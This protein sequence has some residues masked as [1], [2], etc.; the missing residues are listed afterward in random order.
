M[1]ADA[2]ILLGF[3]LLAVLLLVGEPERGFSIWV[4]LY[5]LMRMPLLLSAGE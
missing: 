4:L 3:V 1:Q 5:A 2:H